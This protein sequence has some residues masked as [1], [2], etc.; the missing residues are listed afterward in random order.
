VLIGTLLAD[1]RANNIATDDICIRA[2][3][4]FPPRKLGLAYFEISIQ[5]PEST[6]EP[7]N[8]KP[9]EPTVSIG[10]S[11]EF[12]NQLWAHVGWNIW[13]AGYHGDDGKFFEHGKPAYPTNRGYGIGNTVGFGIDYDSNKYFSTL[14]GAVVC[15]APHPLPLP[16][17]LLFEILS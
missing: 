15:R 5:K 8:S 12:S 11:G 13:S 6:A 7:S 4:P 2:D 1:G 16:P 9:L 10:F 14:D 17:L 3:F